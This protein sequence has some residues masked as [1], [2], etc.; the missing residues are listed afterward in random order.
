MKRE[1]YYMNKIIMY[2]AY[3]KKM[4]ST[5]ENL[6]NKNII[7][8][9]FLRKFPHGCCSDSSILLAELLYRNN[10]SCQYVSGKCYF[11][12]KPY[13]HAWVVVEGKIII[14]VTGDQFGYNNDLLNYNHKVYVGE[15]DEF[16]KLFDN[17]DIS[18]EDYFGIEMYDDRTKSR[19][20]ELYNKIDDHI[21]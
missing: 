2:Q 15:L 13:Y 8:D 16:H 10:I 17:E 21:N 4:R 9:K 5:I 12:N 20:K 1:I 3:A 14:D 19:L 11:D 7:N 6:I 18:V